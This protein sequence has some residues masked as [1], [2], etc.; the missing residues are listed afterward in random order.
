MVR[1]GGH[2]SGRGK[3]YGGGGGGGSGGGRGWS[4]RLK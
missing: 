1:T 2:L 3:A 4:R